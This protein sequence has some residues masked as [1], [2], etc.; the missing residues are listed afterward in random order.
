MFMTIKARIILMVFI[1]EITGYGLL[2]FYISSSYEKDLI[3]LRIQNIQ[4]VFDE[5]LVRVNELTQTMERNVEHLADRGRQL[6][7]IRKQVPRTIVVPLIRQ[8]LVDNFSRFPESIGGGLWYEP[9][10]FYP[11]DR[12]FGPYA[13]RDGTQVTFREPANKSLAPLAFRATGDQGSNC[14]HTGCLSKIANTE[15]RSL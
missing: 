1:L 13:Y 8:V 12:L 5:N 3:S 6:F 14:R 4:A 10:Q 15:I 7:S 9:F 11:Q 2:L